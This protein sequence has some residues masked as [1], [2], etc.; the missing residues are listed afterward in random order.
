MGKQLS[1]FP[2]TPCG[3][4]G[5]VDEA[6]LRGLLAPLR[7]AEVDSIGLLGSTGTYAYLSREER[8]RAL[9]I[10]VDKVGGRVP[11]LV[12]VGALRTD[13]TVRLARDAKAVGATAGLLAPVSYTPLTDDEVFEHFSVVARES[14]LPLV[15]YDNPGTTHFSFGPE[16][17]A[18]V[19]RLPGVIAMKSPAPAA[20]AVAAHVER[21][22]QAVPEGFSVGCSGDW[23]VTEALIG[24]ADAWYSVAAGLFPKVCLAIV[25]AAERGEAEEARRLDAA[26]EPL[27]VLFREYSSLRVVYAAAAIL[28]LTEAEPPHPILPLPQAVRERIAETLRDLALS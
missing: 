17:V 4:D 14:G 18:R 22:R 6:G 12:G 3:P 10:A 28:G 1:A 5:R 23:H 26:L 13:E 11:V 19:S 15:I 20:S 8:R 21:L 25:R 27:W 16:L 2:I 24:G 7:E 9:E